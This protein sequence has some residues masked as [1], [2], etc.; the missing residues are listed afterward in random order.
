[1]WAQNWQNI[2]ALV[3]PYNLPEVNYDAKI[4]D[5]Y[6]VKRLFRTA[7]QF[8]SSLGLYNMTDKFWQYSML[9]RPDDDTEVVCHASAS[10]MFTEDDFR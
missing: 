10:D 5:G 3:K 6:D 4:K 2:Y 7:E 9:Q 8:Y 1:M